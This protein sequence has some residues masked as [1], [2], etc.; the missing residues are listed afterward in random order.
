MRYDILYPLEPGP[1]VSTYL[2]C[3]KL[4]QN[5]PKVLK[6]IAPVPASVPEI[7]EIEKLFWNRARFENPY[8]PRLFDVGFRAKRIGFIFEFLDRPLFPSP[9]TRLSLTT[10]FDLCLQLSLLIEHLHA[11]RFYFGYL[12]PSKLFVRPQGRLCVNIPLPFSALP[13]QQ[14]PRQAVGYTAPELLDGVSAG[15]S[16]DLYSLGMILYF[17]LS[18]CPPFLEEDPGVLREKM[19]VARPSRLR[20]LA[21]EIPQVIEDLIH[22]LTEIDPRSRPRDA[23]YATSLFRRFTARREN[24]FQR[25]LPPL[26][27]RP[28]LVSFR[29]LCERA[30]HRPGLHWIDIIGEQGAE[31][32]FFCHQAETIAKISGFQTLSWKAQSKPHSLQTC[33][34]PHRQLKDLTS[35][36]RSAYHGQLA[37]PSL[38][39]QCTS[40]LRLH[41]AGVATDPPGPLFIGITDSEWSDSLAESLR[42]EFSQPPKRA[43]LI[44]RVQDSTSHSM[45][46]QLPGSMPPD[47]VSRHS[48]SLKPYSRAESEQLISALLEHKPDP[49]QVRSAWLHCGGNPFYIE[50]FVNQHTGR[51]NLGDPS[52][53]PQSRLGVSENIF[54]PRLVAEDIQARI[55]SLSPAQKELLAALSVVESP[56]TDEFLETILNREKKEIEVDVQRLTGIGL[57][58]LDASGKKPEM[59]PACLWIREGSRSCYPKSGLAALHTRIAETL[60]EAFR[61]APSLELSL[62]VCRHFLGSDRPLPAKRYIWLALFHLKSTRRFSEA[63]DLIELAIGQRLLQLTDWNCARH[64]V[65]FLFACGRLRRC[66]KLLDQLLSMSHWAPSQRVNLLLM[67]G[68]ISGVRGYKARALDQLSGALQI[69][70]QSADTEPR[71][72]LDAL[73]D[74][75]CHLARIGRPDLV[76]HTAESVV[77][78]LENGSLLQD[79]DKLQH[80][81]SVYQFE[82]GD[83][84]K[85]VTHEVRAIALAQA[86]GNEAA[87]LGRLSNVASF[88]LAMGRWDRHQ[89]VVRHL[90]AMLPLINNQELRLYI[91]SASAILARK[92][93]RHRCAVRRL[94][95]LFH[96]NSQNNRSRHLRSELL[97][98]MIRNQAHLLELKCCMRLFR[99]HRRY[100]HRRNAVSS[101]LDLALTKARFWLQAGLPQRAL[102]ELDSLSQTLS[103]HLEIQ[104]RLMRSEICLRLQDLPKALQLARSV[105]A[106]LPCGFSYWRAQA[107]LLEGEILLADSNL[108]EAEWAIEE[109]LAVSKQ[110][111]FQPFLAKAYLC[112]SRWLLENGRLEMARLFAGRSLQ[113]GMRLQRPLLRSETHRLLAKIHLRLKQ[114]TAAVDHLRQAVLIVEQALS[115]I[116]PALLRSFKKAHLRPAAFEL[117]QLS[118]RSSRKRP[119]F[120]RQTRHFMLRLQQ[121]SC[122]Q[123]V[124]NELVATTRRSLEPVSASC[125]LSSGTNGGSF[126]KAAGSG[127]CSRSATALLPLMLKDNGLT[128]AV[129][130]AAPSSPSL[131][132]M[133]LP[134]RSGRKLLGFLYLERHGQE[135]RETEVDF[136]KCITGAAEA[137][138]A[139]ASIGNSRELP[140]N[141]VGLSLGGKD[142][143]VGAHPKMTEL[144]AT[145]VRSAATSV[146]ILIEGESGTGKELVARAIHHYSPLSEKPFVAVNCG[147]FPEDLIENELFGH[148][149]GSFTGAS[150]AKMGLLEAASGGTLFLDEISSL[151]V[152]LQARFLRVLEQQSVRRLGE[153]HERPIR[154]RFVSA[155][156]QPLRR[157]VQSGQFRS[158]LF[159]RLNVFRISLPTLRERL[160]DIPLL[161]RFFLDRLNQESGRE[162]T[163]HPDALQALFGYTFPGNVRELKNI[164]ESSFHCCSGNRIMRADVL[165]RLDANPEQ[166]SAREHA[167]VDEIFEQLLEGSVDFWSAVRDAYLRRDLSRQD[168]RKLISRA[169]EETGGSYKKLVTLFHLPQKEYK[170]LL[171]FL[172]H[173]DCQVDFRQFRR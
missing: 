156:N 131:A 95:R 48:L 110:Q 122:G 40:P 111:F 108:K 65:D 72:Y 53:K 45:P 63:A 154:V 27:S 4:E 38:Q 141:G 69:L 96:E 158:D 13:Q 84:Q 97:L 3:D 24:G 100:R 41:S 86:A 107:R 71:V 31:T 8:L 166:L 55:D 113:I 77:T 33:Q 67:S 61:H 121:A 162:V 117:A 14:V 159:H 85:A 124:A 35:S 2:V 165:A 161:C 17:L 54:I 39:A 42:N 87:C 64:L 30:R 47:S 59:A 90:N 50:Q 82:A 92:Q 144:F 11:S 171:G 101:K 52:A 88:Y 146:T 172:R 151:P 32:R 34:T 150:K 173:H 99:R 79:H 12:T 152:Q 78:G 75:L 6:L 116:P 157:L 136:L 167:K 145:I 37:S 76:R 46:A 22:S 149:E 135:F 119:E 164:V 26:L 21:P 103:G 74:Y 1:D 62:R 83:L 16:S 102:R 106:D 51:R 89:A 138:F 168:V 98:E 81:L 36:G 56:V 5:S 112:K 9:S 80:A 57:V 15:A 105:A 104:V 137:A 129:D 49:D 140:S 123:D 163:L 115:Q 148:A 7:L 10:T 25:R 109:A 120:L 44:A 143:L 139:F 91:R 66:H 118:R 132:T 127:K 23:S 18:G 125:W 68:R 155:T 126:H 94:K 20:T 130:R 169:L 70:Q 147:A 73:G 170:K 160:S 93:G 29:T 114:R 60:E 142:L 134:L 58:R 128:I 133:A 28:E 43:V 153:N 19:R